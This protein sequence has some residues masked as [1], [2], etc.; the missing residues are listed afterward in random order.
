MPLL[1]KLGNYHIWHRLLL[2]PSTLGSFA[3]SAATELVNSR[4]RVEADP[5]RNARLVAAG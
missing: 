2:I 4:S 3:D 5:L 1:Q